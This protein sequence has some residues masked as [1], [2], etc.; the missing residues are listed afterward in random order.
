MS[1]HLILLL[2]LVGAAV[3]V[4]RLPDRRPSNVGETVVVWVLVGYCGIPMIGFMLFGLVHPSEVAGMVG[5]E[6]G[7]PFQIFTTWALLGMGAAATLA[8]RYRGAY[9]VGPS[10]AWAIFFVGATMIHLHQYDAA[11]HLD[12]SLG[13]LVFATHGLISLLLLGGLAASGAWRASQG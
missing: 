5:F 2:V 4:L 10:L 7:S 12:A 9:L 6:P 11:G 13:L 1:F 8:V 3:H